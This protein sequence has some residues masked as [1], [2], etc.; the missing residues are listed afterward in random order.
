[1]R[2]EEQANQKE[3]GDDDFEDLKEK[4]E[5][6]LKSFHHK[7][8]ACQMLLY[9]TLLR[10]RHVMMTPFYQQSSTAFKRYY[11]SRCSVMLHTADYDTYMYST[12]IVI[13]PLTHREE[14]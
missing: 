4:V 2:F 6:F 10:T 5:A 9:C 12:D 11:L 7:K 14:G 1:M 8:G 3:Q 13:A